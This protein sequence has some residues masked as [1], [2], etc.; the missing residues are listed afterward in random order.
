MDAT[1]ASSQGLVLFE[2]KLMSLASSLHH[3]KAR[4]PHALYQPNAAARSI[5]TAV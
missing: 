1:H 5:A 4:G 2:Q 3:Q